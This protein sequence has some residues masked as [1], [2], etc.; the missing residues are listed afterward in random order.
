MSRAIAQSSSKA[1][2]G[3]SARMAQH[4]HVQHVHVHVHGTLLWV[5][6]SVDSI[7]GTWRHAAARDTRARGTAAIA[8]GATRLGGARLQACEGHATHHAVGWA[9]G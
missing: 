2:S 9:M 8:K 7:W 6:A 1:S 4:V 3:E 5:H